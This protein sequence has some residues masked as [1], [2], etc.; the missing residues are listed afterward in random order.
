MCNKTK[1]TTTSELADWCEYKFYR[2]VTRQKMSEISKELRRLE[3]EAL[4]LHKAGCDSYEEQQ[5]RIEELEEKLKN[6]FNKS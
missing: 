6:A 4:E 1:Q 5:A 2:S 3:K